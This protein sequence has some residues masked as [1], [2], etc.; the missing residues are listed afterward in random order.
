MVVAAFVAPFLMPA[1]VRFV[2]TAAQLPGVRLAGIT[3]PPAEQVAVELARHL[4][5]HLGSPARPR[6]PGA[7][8]ADPAPRRALAG[9]RPARPAADRRR[10]PGPLAAAR[11]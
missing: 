9:G 11:A 3:T 5:A 8:R 2:G 6:R 10:R 1:T 7:G 4:R